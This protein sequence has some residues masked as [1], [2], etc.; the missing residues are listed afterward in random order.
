MMQFLRVDTAY[1]KD[2]DNQKLSKMIK[3]YHNTY[4]NLT[5]SVWDSSDRRAEPPQYMLN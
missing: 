3:W 1:G 2:Q 4:N 5:T